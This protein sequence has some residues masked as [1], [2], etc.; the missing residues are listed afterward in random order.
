LP[1]A[2][3]VW[4]A[5]AVLT[6][7]VLSWFGALRGPQILAFQVLLGVVWLVLGRRFR[8]LARPH[9][10][11]NWEWWVVGSI[12]LISLCTAML[13]AP[14]NF[15]SM[16]YHMVKVDQWLQSGSLAP[17]AVHFAPQVY[18]APAAEMGIAVLLGPTGISV[19]PNLVQAGALVAVIAAAVSLAG[20]LGA[21]P[22]AQRAAA[23]LVA[24]TPTVVAEAPTT[25]NDLV[26]SALV[27]TCAALVA[28][29]RRGEASIPRL[30]SVSLAAAV[31]VAVKPTA[32][33]F[34]APVLIWFM[35]RRFRRAWARTISVA[36][37]SVALILVVNVGWLARNVDVY[38]SPAGPPSHLTNAEVTPGVVVGNMLRNAGHNLGTPL[39]SVNRAVTAFLGSSM[40]AAGINPD[41]PGSLYGSDAFS[42]DS[43]RNE[44]RNSSTPQ[45]LLFLA[46]LVVLAGR[47]TVRAPLLPLLACISVGYTAFSTL[48][49]WQ[50]WGGR[51]LLPLTVL[52][53][54]VAATAIEV[55]ARVM[56][57]RAVTLLLV[58]V[59]C[60]PWL[61]ASKWRPLV[62]A[63]SVVTTSD[64]DDR[65]RARPE[66]REPTL[67]L[68]RRIAATNA[69]VVGIGRDVYVWEYP[70]RVAIR[71]LRPGV[72][73][74][75][76][77]T[78]GPTSRFEDP[79]RPAVVVR[80]D[81]KPTTSG[82]IEQTLG[83]GLR[84]ELDPARV[85]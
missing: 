14:N 48:F 66:L 6:C 8:R 10:V 31:A 18:L 71:E 79:R 57:L 53:C 74:V 80:A 28:H 46:S 4:L 3:A 83:G 25:Q 34:V 67:E 72:T 58:V 61:V 59:L 68:A 50:V 84:L 16:A 51:L 42:V 27:V 17:F 73:F 38:G 23:V 7:E 29:L 49:A 37:I 55:P 76:V 5:W 33:L 11:R 43:E 64:V 63:E 40:R 2:Y 15:D 36:V 44:D 35:V 77:D 75:N 47:R 65:F 62:G 12:V 9:A 13:A 1:L 21:S 69:S 26:A 41:D 24:A 70:L 22:A 60:L 54:V 85:K 19:A 39:D 32:A 20:D 78:V 82:Y 45:F 52:G 81:L 56:I 30:M